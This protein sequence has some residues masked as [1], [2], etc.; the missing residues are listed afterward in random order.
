MRQLDPHY[1]SGATQMN[2]FE[3]TMRWA[4]ITFT[5]DD[6]LHIDLDFW[7]DYFD[8]IHA[9]GVVFSTGGYIAYHATNIPFQYSSR[10][11]YGRDLFGESVERARQRDMAVIA[12]TDPHAMHQDAFNAH[13][14]WAHILED[15]TPW[16]HWSMPGVWVTCALGPF[17]FEFMN[18]VNKEIMAKYGVDAIFGN[19]WTGNGVCYCA[20]CQANFKEATGLDIPRGVPRSNPPMRVY[21]NWR[22]QRL[23]D[24][25][26]VW[27]DA[28]RSINPDGHYIPNSGGGALSQLN[29][30]ETGR[31]ARILFAD[32]QARSGVMAPWASGKNAKEF[33][34]TMD[35]KP[36]GGIFSVGVEEPHRWK[37]SSQH[38][39]ELRVWVA[40]LIA[41]GMRPWFTK[42]CAQ[43]H[44]DRW[45]PVV[46]SIYR[47]HHEIED[48]QREQKPLAQVGLVYSQQTARTYGGDDPHATV[49]DHIRGF[50]HALIEARIPFEMVHDERLEL[51][52]LEPFKTLILPNIAALSDAQCAVIR[53][54]VKN[55]GGLI[56]TFHSSLFDENGEKRANFGLADLFGADYGGATEGPM[57]NSYLNLEGSPGDRHPL[58]RGMDRVRRIINGINRVV[59]NPQNFTINPPLTLVPAYPDL[60]MEEVYPREPHTDIPGV[61]L[62]DAHRGRVV[63][64]PWDIDRTFWEI[65][66]VDH[67]TLLANAVRWATAEPALVEVEGPGVLDVTVWRQPLSMTVHLVNLTNPMLMK[68]PIR[69]LIPVGEQIVHL[70]LPQGDRVR[71][72]QLLKADLI[73]QYDVEGS[74]LTVRVPMVLDHEIVAISLA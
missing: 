12:R 30:A 2:I 42:F 60:P 4:Q 20:S 57:K 68:G 39:P 59:A 14:E 25:W 45:L 63:Y 15:G 54:F 18:D 22:E 17:N 24:L 7:F 10:H 13:P 28:I 21:A 56:A 33:R 50:Y 73:P 69:E 51:A 67:G 11:L 55:G 36:I 44:D 62:S 35:D 37:D 5:E 9:D 34:A 40:D 48:Y 72:V 31:R 52:R 29:M 38:D 26:K 19:R 16:A 53:E 46:E 70:R 61:F 71:A 58:L 43:L 3:R 41:N 66:N 65:L 47:W 64:F 27:D 74:L 23:F 49:E 6:P 8:R 1:N 32:R